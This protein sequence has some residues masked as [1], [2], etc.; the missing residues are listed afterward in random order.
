MSAKQTPPAVIR[1]LIARLLGPTDVGRSIAGDL[2]EEFRERAIRDPR[3]ARRWYRREALG[4]AVRSRRIARGRAAAMAPK[5]DPIMQVLWHDLRGAVRALVKQPRFTVVAAATLAVG[6]A[7][8]T[9]IFS[10]VNGVL[11]KPLPYPHAER[12]VNVRSTA[13]GLGY[14][15]FPQ[16]PDLYL[17]FREHSDSFEDLAIYQARRANLTEME[18]PIVVD[19]SAASPS[20]FST[21]SATFAQGRPFTVEEDLPKAT[22]VAVV[23]HRFWMR[24]RGGRAGF[25]GES[26]RI[27]GVSR[28]VVGI[29][30][31]WLDARDT[32][33]VWIPTGFDPQNPTIGQFGWN[34]IGRLEPGI[35]PETA[36]ARL[37]A[38]VKQAMGQSGTSSIYQ[39]F[40]ND[41]KYRPIVLDMKQDIV[42]DVRQ[43]LWILLGT[44]GMVLLIA[45]ANVANLFLI[46]AEGRQRE[47]AVRVALG[48]RRTTLVRQLLSE[49]LVLSAVGTALGVLLSA[50]ALPAILALAPTSIPRLDQVRLD[51][52]VVLFAIAAAAISAIVFGLVPAL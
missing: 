29:A 3:T 1:S 24:H 26:I 21:L 15:E 44:V 51:V 28:Q 5:G 22:P 4:V 52:N 2:D 8:V 18:T 34:V 7:A 33:D 47:I 23:S 45:C 11:I 30:P 49:A 48:G 38:L 25:V 32:P 42:G 20:F 16:S 41:G 36:E 14:P 6:I 43:P 50:S 12:L 17:Y 40:I 10:V 27:D 35:S 39:A 13:P 19:I 9:S 37:D 46:R 31:A